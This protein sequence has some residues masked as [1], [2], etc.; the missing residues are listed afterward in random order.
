MGCLEI[1]INL[2]AFDLE[3]IFGHDGTLGNN[4]VDGSLLHN[5]GTSCRHEHGGSA[6]RA[7]RH[8]QDGDHQGHGPGVGQARHRVQLLGSNGL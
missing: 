5:A 1:V 4:S 8:R 3:R 6:R 2:Y 7:R